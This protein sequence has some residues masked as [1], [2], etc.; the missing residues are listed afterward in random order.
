MVE[1]SEGAPVAGEGLV[2]KGQAGGRLMPGPVRVIMALTGLSLVVGLVKLFMRWVLGFKREGRVVVEA[3]DLSVEETTRFAGREIK[4]A[5]ERFGKAEVVSA[6]LETRYPYLPTL[7]GLAGLGLGVVLGLLW[8]LDGI[9]GE[10]TPWILAGVGALLLGVALDL[11]MTAVASSMPGRTTV[12][13]RLPERR[14]VRLV[15]CDPEVAERVV[16]WLHDRH[17]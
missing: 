17:T 15:G 1:V 4:S 16:L 6:R 13:L 8:L 14:V 2:L 9:Q 3:G 5:R 7:V 11:A 12:V 10:F